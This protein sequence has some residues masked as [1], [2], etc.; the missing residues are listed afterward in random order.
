MTERQ[1]WVGWLKSGKK[2]RCPLVDAVQS[3]YNRRLWF[4]RQTGYWWFGPPPGLNWFYFWMNSRVRWAQDQCLCFLLMM[5]FCWLHRGSTTSSHWCNC[6]STLFSAGKG[7]RGRGI[8]AV[9]Q[10]WVWKH[11]C[12]YTCC[13]TPSSTVTCDHEL[14]VLD[15]NRSQIWASG[16]SIKMIVRSLSCWEGLRVDPRHW[17][18]AVEGVRG[19]GYIRGACLVAGHLDLYEMKRPSDDVWIV[20]SRQFPNS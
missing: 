9:M 18:G 14:W 20:F 17:K 3:V 5:W 6:N 12:G 8:D 16:L 7:R 13:S 11:I 15:Q 1:R 19:P 4:T 10:S 2:V